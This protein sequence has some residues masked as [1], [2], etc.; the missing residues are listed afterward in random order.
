MKGAVVTLV[1]LIVLI[2]AS[3]FVIYTVDEKEQ[4]VIT[5]VGEVVRVVKEPGLYFKLPFP[6]QKVNLFDKRILEYDADPKVIYTKD[7]KNL[8][9][10][11][12]ARWRIADPKT[13]LE[14]IRTER[15][16]QP[17]LD[18]IVYAALREELGKHTLIEVISEERKNI[19][20]T[21]TTLSR[22]NAQDYGIE[23]IDVRIKRADLPPENERSVFD[24]MKAE[25]S[26]QAKQ[27]RSEGEEEA[28]KIRAQ[29][30]LDAA[31]ISAEAYK[32]AQEMKGQGDAEALK[33]YAQAYQR[34][35]AFYEFVRTLEAYE[36]SIDAN[37]VLVL[38][39]ESDFFR[40]LADGISPR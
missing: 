25:R 38:P 20:E 2:I 32:R 28:L 7:K 24:R 15:S 10:D 26:R 16:A 13:F 19:M 1:I 18:D 36:V 27:Y 22:K 8:I 17:R 29:T 23:V 14:K 21:V 37:T 39:P 40:Y 9:V 33:I 4:V 34:D 3:S 11:N 5:Q 12:Y 35:P 6:M 30:D 31:T